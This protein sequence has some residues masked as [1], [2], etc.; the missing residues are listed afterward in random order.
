MAKLPFKCPQCPACCNRDTHVEL[1]VPM[2]HNERMD[3]YSCHCGK[4]GLKFRTTLERYTWLARHVSSKSFG[5]A[6]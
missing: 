4:C 1:M 3:E 6:A 2:P 5:L